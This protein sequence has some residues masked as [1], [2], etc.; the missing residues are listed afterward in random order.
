M[1]GNRPFSCLNVKALSA[2]STASLESSL[3]FVRKSQKT[4]P[5]HHRFWMTYISPNR[6]QLTNQTKNRI[7][8]VVHLQN[9]SRLSALVQ[10]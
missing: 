8:I 4:L 2:K 3:H 10:Q 9:W 6:A 1:L 5:F 7:E